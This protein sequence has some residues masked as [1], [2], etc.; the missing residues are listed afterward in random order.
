MYLI[1]RTA[2]AYLGEICVLDDEFGSEGSAVQICSTL[3]ISASDPEQTFPEIRNTSS[4][5]K[6]EPMP[7]MARHKGAPI[8]NGI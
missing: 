3:S 1:D 2:L 4:M 6:A 5:R 8:H 7:N